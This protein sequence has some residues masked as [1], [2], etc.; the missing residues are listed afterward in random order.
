M[1]PHPESGKKKKKKK[2]KN[3]ISHTFGVQDVLNHAQQ[4]CSNFRF[5]ESKLL[6]VTYPDPQ[7]DLKIRSP[8][9]IWEII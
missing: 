4:E 1:T 8:R 3:I 2:K 6:E 5:D 7:K 9:T